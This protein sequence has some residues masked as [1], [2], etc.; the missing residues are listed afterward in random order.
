MLC[1]H[2]YICPRSKVK[3]PKMRLIAALC[4]L[5][6]PV[7]AEIPQVVTDIPPV[8]ALV[9]QVMGDLGTPEL[10]LTQG[11]D[12]HDFQLRPSQM[13]LLQDADLIFWI[14]AEL[15]PW[16]DRAS[17]SSQG[18]SVILLNL[19]QT[20]TQPYPEMEPHDAEDAEDGDR[21]S[22]IDPHVWLNPQNAAIWLPLIA[23]ELVKAD[24]D[25][26][27]TYSANAEQAQAAITALDAEIAAMLAPIR[28]E[29]FVTYHNAYG[30][31]ASHYALFYAG[32]IADGEAAEP[33]AAHLTDL[34]AHLTAD[35]IACVFPEAQHDP[36]LAERLL[37]GST[38]RLGGG[39]DPVGSTLPAGPDAYAALIR[40]LATTLVACLQG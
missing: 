11:A 15:T 28:D 3:D 35:Q 4:L 21:H 37:E 14:G 39:L 26:A 7:L 9:S 13:Q 16:L 29:P 17:A 24:P 12:E 2:I 36:A 1:Y 10:L 6:L 20:L 27:A 32:S 34:Q 33:G 8:H 18:T 25:N 40:G 31:F 38:A 19:P 30:Y 22:G 23:A 5:P